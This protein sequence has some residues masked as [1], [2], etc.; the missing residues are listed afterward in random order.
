MAGDHGKLL[1]VLT[2]RDFAQ[3]LAQAGPS[4]GGMPVRIFVQPS[5]ARCRSSDEVRDALGT[6]RTRRVFA[7]PVVDGADLFLGVLTF[8]DL[9]LAARPERLA[10]PS[11]L[12]DE[13]LLLALKSMA[14]S[15]RPLEERA[16]APPQLAHL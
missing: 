13:D 3:A 9:A 10:G 16:P 11:D 5:L 1:G 4:A 7:L 12:T 6:M 14:A 8:G 2:G 15:R